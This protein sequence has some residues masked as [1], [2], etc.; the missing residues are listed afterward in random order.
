MLRVPVRV[1]V[2]PGLR[3]RKLQP[4]TDLADLERRIRLLDAKI[5][6]LLQRLDLA[7][8]GLREKLK[9]RGEQKRAAGP[10]PH[11]AMLDRAGI[12]EEAEGLLREI[13]DTYAAASAEDQAQI[14]TMFRDFCHFSWAIGGAALVSLRDA[15]SLTADRCRDV[16]T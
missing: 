14:R 11:A 10:Q 5:E 9:A 7:D 16:L 15:E 1:R 3:L 12:R 2:T 8:P 6:P 13:L 4:M